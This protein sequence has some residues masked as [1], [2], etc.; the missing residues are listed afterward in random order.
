[1]SDALLWALSA[2]WGTAAGVLLPRAAY[3]FAVVA[4]EGW[5]DRCPHGHALRGWLG[6][7]RCGECA[8]GGAHL[9][10]PAHPVET[11]PAHPVELP[12][13]TE[14]PYAAAPA[15][16]CPSPPT[17]TPPGVPSAPLLAL[18]A[19]LTCVALAAATGARP[20]LAVWLLLAPV[21]VLLAVID[22]RVQRLPDPLTLPLA[23]AALAL[24]GLAALLPGH[25]G[26]WLTALY[27]ALALG[28]GYFV[29]FLINPSGMGFGDVKLAVG[30]GAVLGWYGW[31]TVLLGT[32]AGFLLG[33]VYGGALV[34]VRRAGRKTAIA[35]GP[36]LIAGAFLGLLAGAYAA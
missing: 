35:F 13:Q 33:A 3:R 24:L 23:V 21:G 6:P 25:A 29:L 31:P 14:P 34:V 32:F 15:H 28:V 10:E 26:H 27:G 2:L 18:A 7:A 36:F 9:T 16:A 22:F 8:R 19:A 12:Q 4:G 11:E 30:M 1:M 20:E 17:A 5:R